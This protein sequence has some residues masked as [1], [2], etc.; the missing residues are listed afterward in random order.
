MLQDVD[1]FLAV[2]RAD[3]D[4]LWSCRWLVLAAVFDLPRLRLLH[5]HRRAGGSP[6]IDGRRRAQVR[7]HPLR[8]DEGRAAG[9]SAK[10]R[11]ALD[12]RE[13]AS[14]YG[15]YARA[16]R[17]A[18]WRLLQGSRALSLEFVA[19]DERQNLYAQTRFEA[20]PP[21]GKKLSFVQLAGSDTWLPLELDSNAP[22]LTTD[23]QGRVYAVGQARL[24]RLE[25]TKVTELP[26]P[27]AV[28]FDF[29]SERFVVT[30]AGGLHIERVTAAGELEP[31]LEAQEGMPVVSVIGFG[32]DHRCYAVVSSD[33][34]FLPTG[35]KYTP[36]DVVSIGK[37]QREWTLAASV[38]ENGDGTFG[39]P[40]LLSS[41]GGGFVSDGSLIWS[42]CESGCGGSGNAFSYGTWRLRLGG[43]P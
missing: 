10:L 34:R 25:G 41:Y 31:W 17:T 12:G 29:S 20:V 13:F 24:F 39:G 9:R 32:R 15:I 21:G 1:A 43:Q 8:L 27:E 2:R 37:G 6:R 14:T 36:G 3:V 22:E 16:D 18:Q 4:V 40:V 26:H 33:P 35:S 28:T 23:F 38:T 11:V 5:R 42:A 7:R 30:P 19:Q